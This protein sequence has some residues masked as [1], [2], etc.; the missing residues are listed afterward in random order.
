MGIYPVYLASWYPKPIGNK[1][2]DN[3]EQLLELRQQHSNAKA[4]V[5]MSCFIHCSKKCT[6]EKAWGD[7]SIPWGY[8]DVWCSKK[9][10]I[11]SQ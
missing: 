6:W 2:P 8:G 3:K 7:H 11:E 1:M 10:L 9:C 5:K 4:I